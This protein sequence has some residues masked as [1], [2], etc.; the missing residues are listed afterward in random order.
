[1]STLQYLVVIQHVKDETAA[2]THASTTP[3]NGEHGERFY[4]AMTMLT[5]V[6]HIG[7]WLLLYFG[8]KNSVNQLTVGMHECVRT[9][10]S[11]AY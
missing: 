1:M 4:K 10:I 7:R 9:F 11:I 2:E 8:R 5:N 3:T 6:K